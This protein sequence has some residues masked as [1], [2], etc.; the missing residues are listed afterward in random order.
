MRARAG[1][2]GLCACLLLPPP[3]SAQGLIGP[4]NAQAAVL[5]VDMKRIKSDT[6]AGRDMLAKTIEIRRRIQA[7]VAERGERLRAEE[8]RL[9]EERETLDPEDFREQVRAFEQ[10]VFANR[11]LSE[12]ETRRLQL[13][14]SGASTLLKDRATAVFAAIMRERR[15]DLLLDS[16][17]IILSADRL[18][19]TDEVIERLDIILPEMPIEL[20]DPEPV[21]RP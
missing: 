17:Q 9:A 15:A 12:R 20:V 4:R 19:I 18:D 1:I 10:Q 16:S 11:E 7:G 6:A 14:L 3:V 8:Q 13:V 2:L 5:V 21:T